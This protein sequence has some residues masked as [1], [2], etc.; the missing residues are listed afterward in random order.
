MAGSGG[1]ELKSTIV[2][3]HQSCFQK[4]G[5]SGPVQGLVVAVVAA[6]HG[7]DGLERRGRAGREREAGEAAPRLADHA[8]RARGP[9]LAG[10]PFDHLDA[11][12][13]LSGLPFAAQEPVGIPR[14]ADVHP[15]A[16]VAVT[17]NVTMNAIV[18]RAEVIALAVGH[19]LDDGRDRLGFRILGEPQPGRQP[20]T[21]G[22]RDEDVLDLADRTRKL[23]DFTHVVP[24]FLTGRRTLAL[25][26]GRA[27]C[28]HVRVRSQALVSSARY[29]RL[30]RSSGKMGRRTR[31]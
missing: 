30:M 8:H 26:H 15:Q 29:G 27:G 3:V 16:R 10:G 4:E 18:A 12:V 2:S 19:V 24:P 23:G 22:E 14:A 17:R 21:V 11:V 13:E 31:R 25:P 20:P 1:R 6:A 9:R 7:N 28:L 5:A